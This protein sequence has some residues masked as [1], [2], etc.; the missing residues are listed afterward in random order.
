MTVDKKNIAKNS[1]KNEIDKKHTQFLSNKNSDCIFASGR[2]GSTTPS[3]LC[4][5]PEKPSSMQELKGHAAGGIKNEYLKITTLTPSPQFL[6]SCSHSLASSANQSVP[7]YSEICIR[8]FV[9]LV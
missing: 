5:D 9:I 7:W 1:A 2:I 4:N 6:A 8:L 3:R